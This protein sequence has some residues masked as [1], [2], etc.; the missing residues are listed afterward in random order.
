MTAGGYF[1][2]RIGI[3]FSSYFLFWDGRRFARDAHSSREPLMFN[4]FAFLKEL[5][6]RRILKRTP[7]FDECWYL[8]KYPDVKAVYTV[9][10]NP[11]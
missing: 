2:D 11:K 5:H 9:R 7:L 1:E 10:Q 4:P 8:R 6:D 3:G